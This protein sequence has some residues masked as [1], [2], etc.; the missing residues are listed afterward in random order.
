MFI[1]F[2][3]FQISTTKE[4]NSCKEMIGLK[5]R[6]LNYKAKLCVIDK[7]SFDLD[8]VDYQ[9]IDEDDQ[10]VYFSGITIDDAA[11]IEKINFNR[12]L[13]LKMK[14]ALK[15]F[16][17]CLKEDLQD[18]KLQ[19]LFNMAYSE[20][21][22]NVEIEQSI[23]G[24]IKISKLSVEPLFGANKKRRRR[25]VVEAL[26]TSF[27]PKRCRY[28]MK[29]KCHGGVR[30]TPKPHLARPASRS[31]IKLHKN[32]FV[33]VTI[34]KRFN[35]KVVMSSKNP[36]RKRRSIVVHYRNGNPSNLRIITRINQN[37][38]TQNVVDVMYKSLKA[39]SHF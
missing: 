31:N 34:R 16:Q 35:K 18:C 2:F 11:K 24:A 33:K 27:T 23:S 8:L 12:D 30:I 3:S 38:P 26:P 21:V 39:L 37:N 25:D 36:K 10:D 29:L 20:K 5:H 9:N 17:K 6:L 32:T 4:N 19:G 7:E 15:K 28:P 13:L 14:K 1:F 22:I